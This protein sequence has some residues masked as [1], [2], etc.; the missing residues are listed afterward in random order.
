MVGFPSF[1]TFCCD[2]DLQTHC[3][4]FERK[5]ALSGITA[6]EGTPLWLRVHFVCSTRLFAAEE[7]RETRLSALTLK[8]KEFLS[9]KVR[10]CHSGS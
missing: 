9:W 4:D 3:A 2:N 7:V 8:P 1:Y 6:L 10:M 5:K